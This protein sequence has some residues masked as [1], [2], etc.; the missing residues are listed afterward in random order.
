LASVHGAVKQL[1]GWIHVATKIGAGTE[2]S[3]YFPSCAAPAHA[4]PLQPTSAATA[5]TAKTI[6]LVEPSPRMRTMMRTALEWNGYRVV[7]TDSSSLAMTLWPGQSKNIDLLLTDV[8][9]PGTMSGRQLADQLRRDKPSMQVLYTYDSA[10]RPAG[11]DQLKV[12]ELVS[13]PFTTIE[14]LESITRSIP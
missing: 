10:E 9:L 2:F 11:L 5:S 13:K 14:L 4:A 7:E 6:L 8:T 3:L 1:E 12:E